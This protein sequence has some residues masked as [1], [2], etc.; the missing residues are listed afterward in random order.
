MRDGFHRLTICLT[1]LLLPA[2]IAAAD[3]SLPG[4]RRQLQLELD[5]RWIGNGV[6]FSPYR[7]GQAP[8]AN[9]PSEEELFADLQLVGYYWRLIRMYDSGEMAQRTLKIIHDRRLLFR[10]ILGVWINSGR[11]PAEQE[12]NRRELATAIRLANAYP[13][14]IAAVAV[15]N[16]AG[17]EWSAH[18]TDPAN[19]VRYVREVRA[20]I[21]QPVTCADDY[22]FWNKEASRVVA[23]EL[24]FIIFHAYALWNGRR[25]DE[26]MAWTAD[27]YDEAVRFHAGIP[28]IIGETGWATSRDATRTKDGEEGALMKAETSVAAQKQYLRQHYRWVAQRKVPTILFEAF[29]EPWKGGGASTPPNIAEKHWGVFDEQRRPKPSFEA[30]SANSTRQ[31]DKRQSRSEARGDDSCHHSLR[32]GIVNPPPASAHTPHVLST[33]TVRHGL[34]PK[35]P[36]NSAASCATGPAA[37]CPAGFFRLG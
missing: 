32:T 31:N 33:T 26:A 1:I 8:G 25:L 18:R 37:G 36:R 3:Q 14:I 27:R 2:A 19:L 13:D 28:V 29:D 34:R 5:G 17:V 15:G 23:A 21:R 16:E 12:E 35:A 11:T 9:V 7:S 20:A 22:N 10:V 4:G 24:D 30:S 6:S